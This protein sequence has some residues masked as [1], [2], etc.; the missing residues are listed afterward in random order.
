VGPVTCPAVTDEPTSLPVGSPIDPIGP[1]AKPDPK[2]NR[3]KRVMMAVGLIVM[4]AVFGWVIPHFAN[5]G[6]VWREVK[7]VSPTWLIVLVLADLVNLATYAPNWMVALPGLR[8][9]QSAEL[10]MAGTAVANVAGAIGGPVSMTM[11][12]AMMREWGFERRHASR[13]MVLTGIWNQF[14]NFGMPIVAVVLL[15]I[16]GGRNAALMVA[17]QIG[18]P[19]L[20]FGLALFFGVLRSESGARRIGRFVDRIRRA[21]A[22]LRRREFTGDSGST[23]VG[24]RRDSIDL[25]RRRWAALTLATTTGVLTVFVVFVC[26]L[27]ALGIPAAQ[28]TFTE[29]FAAWAATR[30]L[31]A[32][33]ITPGGIGIIDVGLIGALIAFGADDA[34]AASAVLLYRV[35][36][37][38]PP[39]V[40]GAIAALT[41]RRGHRGRTPATTAG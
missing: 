6:D 22:R 27:R 36:T 37:W 8:Y 13:A 30:L 1:A 40:L 35:L 31:S 34:K 21:I 10:T 16:R 28:I 4:I 17:A 29:A 5:Y 23:F 3:K 2:S 20:V 14:V 9:R 11:Q 15:S 39:V 38:L 19:L 12:Y 18:F 24:F 33:P 41:W 7:T 32:I 25:L 26:T